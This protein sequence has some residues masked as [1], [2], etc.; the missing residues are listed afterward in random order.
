M[1]AYL[2]R[3]TA[4]GD[5]NNVLALYTS[6]KPDGTINGAALQVEFDIPVY[7]YAEPTGGA[8]VKISGVNYSD[9]RAASNLNN[10]DITI[11]GGMAKGLPLANPAQ[12]GILLRGTIFQCWGNWQGR[13]TSLE[14]IVYASAG[15]QDA[16]VNLAGVWRQGDT[17]EAAIRQALGIAYPGVPVSG[18]L[19]S[20]L[21]YPQ[22]QPYAYQN[23]QQ[24]NKQ[25][26]DMSH[27]I[28]PA[29]SYQGVQI[30]RQGAGFFI[31][32]GTVTQKSKP[33]SFLDLIGQPTWLDPG[34]MQFR[35]VLRADVNGGDTVQMPVG[36]PL[37]NT[38]GASPSPL[39]QDKYV[40][41]FN[42]SFSVRNIR[43]L[44]NSR[45]SSAESWIS[46]FDCYTNQTQKAA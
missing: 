8:T 11:Y 31:T 2:I 39:T 1:R 30:W 45:Q 7:S 20:S 17:M 26:A 27:G 10:A 44:G 16:P 23:L 29:A 5:P 43:H 25:L 14:M 4:P 21:V 40:T 3:I 33:I 34:T 37:I 18:G 15:S 9:I 12:A 19:S 28:I 42:G 24:M 41:A 46:V 13:D 38:A 22:D 35:T 32:D 36:S 6:F